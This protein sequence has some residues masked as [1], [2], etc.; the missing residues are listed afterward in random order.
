MTVRDYLAALRAM[1]VPQHL[2][3]LEQDRQA[4]VLLKIDERT[5]RRYRRGETP[6]PGPVQVALD[7][8]AGRR[9]RSSLL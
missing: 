5:A 4:A 1:G 8:L 2:P 6:I 7:C 9:K 3:V